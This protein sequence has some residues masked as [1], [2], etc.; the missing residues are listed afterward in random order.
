MSFVFE[1]DAPENEEFVE[2]LRRT[3]SQPARNDAA[4]NA[5]VIAIKKQ[6]DWKTAAGFIFAGA[7]ASTQHQSNPTFVLAIGA[8][9]VACLAPL[10]LKMISDEAAELLELIETKSRHRAVD[11]ARM[12]KLLGGN[13]ARDAI[14][15]LEKA[16]LVRQESNGDWVVQRIRLASFRVLG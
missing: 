1:Y 5:T 11:F 9:I 10:Q 14:A 16:G 6:I 12:Q 13:S 7:T 4:L 8:V 3:L 2:T 15:A